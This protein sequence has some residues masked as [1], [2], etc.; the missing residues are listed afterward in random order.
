MVSCAVLTAAP[1]DAEPFPVLASAFVAAL[2][3]ALAL[4]VVAAAVLDVVDDAPVPERDAV[5]EAP[6]AD[7][8]AI[9]EAGAVIG[10]AV[11]PTVVAAVTV[12]PGAFVTAVPGGVPALV[13]T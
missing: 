7:V 3:A 1:A 10:V 11:V 6:A 4:W 12:P 2:R 5:D 9:A 8:V 13:A